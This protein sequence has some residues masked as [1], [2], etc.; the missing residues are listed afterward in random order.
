MQKRRPE[1]AVEL[2]DETMA[3]EEAL[4]RYMQFSIFRGRSECP[5]AAFPY[6]LTDSCP[7]GPTRTMCL[8]IKKR[9]T[10]SR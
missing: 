2:E 5:P 9:S 7:L 10:F 3:M 1:S 8:S 4:Q 6:S